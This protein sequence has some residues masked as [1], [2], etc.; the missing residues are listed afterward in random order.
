M[1][2][3]HFFLKKTCGGLLLEFGFIQWNDLFSRWNRRHTQKIKYVKHVIMI[4]DI[5][6]LLFFI[7]NSKILEISQNSQENPRGCNFFKN[8]TL[9]QVFSCEF[10]A[11][12]KNTFSTE[13]LWMTVS[14]YDGIFLYRRFNLFMHKFWG[15]VW[16]SFNI[17]HERD[18]YYVQW[19]H[20]EKQPLKVFCK[21]SCS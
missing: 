7:G 2:P 12:F 17:M 11:M 18:N 8:G 10:C 16:W 9:V 15:C 1:F 14:D 21:N 13:H 19:I 6:C 20:F 5:S 3:E 4:C